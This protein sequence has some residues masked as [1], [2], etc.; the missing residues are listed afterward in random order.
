MKKIVIFGAVNPVLK[1]AKELE[2][3]MPISEMMEKLIFG[4]VLLK[5]GVEEL[6]SRPYKRQL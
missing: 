5:D 6:L 1:R 3:E 4:G 2:I